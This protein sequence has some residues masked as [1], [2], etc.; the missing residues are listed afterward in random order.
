MCNLKVIYDNNE[1]YTNKFNLYKYIIKMPL[2]D[3]LTVT[4][5]LCLLPYQIKHN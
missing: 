2:Q 3:V 4:I 1:G 5:N